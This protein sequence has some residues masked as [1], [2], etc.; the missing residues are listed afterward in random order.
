MPRGGATPYETPAG[1]DHKGRRYNGLRL[2]QWDT[3]IF[4]ESAELRRFEGCVNGARE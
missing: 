2:C 4:R 3:H 1:V